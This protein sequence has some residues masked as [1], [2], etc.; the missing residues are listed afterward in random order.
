MPQAQ[1]TLAFAF[2][3]GL[4][5]LAGSNIIGTRTR[6]AGRWSSWIARVSS[7]LRG[8]PRRG[9]WPLHDVSISGMEFTQTR[10]DWPEVRATSF[11]SPARHGHAIR[12]ENAER[13]TIRGN[14]ILGPV[15]TGFASRGTTQDMSSPKTRSI[16]PAVR[17][18][19]W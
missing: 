9:G 1:A 15:R 7:G 6:T 17:G 12:L 11:Y 18:F 3:E 16:R 14:R 2:G 4:R 13:C 10:T 5:W 8:L 19:P